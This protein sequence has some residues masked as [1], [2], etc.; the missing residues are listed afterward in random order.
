MVALLLITGLSLVTGCKKKSP[1]TPP[2]EP[3]E[4]E[5]TGMMDSMKNAADETVQKTTETVKET[6][7]AVKEALT[8]DINLEKTVADLKAEAAQMDIESLQE[9]AAKYKKAIAEN[10]AKLKALMDKLS[11][12]PL[13]EKLG[14][15]AQALTGE[16][17]AL[18]D[19]VSALQQRFQVYIDALTAKG[20]DV[21]ALLG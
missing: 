4:Q 20:A 7:A 12:I 8:T 14:K 11:A 5:T 1:V 16:I 18:T 15:E 21:K 9:I 17:K 3:S 6:T 19:G 13:T 2:A 10:E